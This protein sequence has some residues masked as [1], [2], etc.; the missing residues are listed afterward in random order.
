MSR[1]IAVNGHAFD[2]EDEPQNPEPV[3]AEH[4][5]QAAF[6]EF[7]A[8]L[9]DFI[10][11]DYPF[12]VPPARLPFAQYVFTVMGAPRFC[13]QV[14]CRRA[15]QCRGGDGPPCYRADREALR[16]ILF[17]WWM[18]AYWGMS[19]EEYEDSLRAKAPRYA[20]LDG[21]P[22]QTRPAARRRRGRR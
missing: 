19:E 14:A 22:P 15:G 8:Q 13:P 16:H 4:D 11:P 6:A 20:A 1:D 9:P 5:E 3:E 18:S 2:H 17:L 21:G 12:D 7:W 10:K